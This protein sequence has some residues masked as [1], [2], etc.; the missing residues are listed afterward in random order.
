MST[1]T[2]TAPPLWDHQE[3][4]IEFAMQRRGSLLAHGMGGGK[5]RTAV[6]IAERTNARCV[7]VLCPKSVVGVWPS[8]FR[9]WSPRDWE[10]WAGR[11][12]GLHGKPLKDPSVAKRAVAAIKAHT[13]SVKLDKP[14]VAV[15]NYESAYLG[16]LAQ[17]TMA[18]EWDLVILDES[19]RCKGASGKQARHA[20]RTCHRTRGRG[21]KALLL[22]GTPMPHSPLDIW[23]QMLAVDSGATLGT[24]YTQFTHHFGQPE[25]YYGPGGVK[26]ERFAGLRDD[27]KDEFAGLLSRH[28]H[29]VP[30]DELDEALGLI[31]PVDTTRICT[32]GPEARQAYDAMQK[33]LLAFISQREV[34]AANA[35]V[36]TTKLAQLSGG[37]CKTPDGDIVY[38]SDPPEKAQLLAD[39]LDEIPADEPIVVFARFHADLDQIARVAA[40]TGRQYGEISGRRR[41]GLSADSKLQPGVLLLGVQLQAGGVGIDLTRAA[42]CVFYSLDFRL[43]D[44]LQSRKRVHRPGQTRR[45]TYVH[46]LAE[47]TL[48]R[49]VIGSLAKREDAVA[50]ALVHIRQAQR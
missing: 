25:E 16:N 42:V 21:G 44:Y 38:A 14:F 6:E 37:F 19:H 50:A 41:D 22:T 18:V 35:M 15:I 32:L 24:S 13:D 2:I 28:I 26:K 11:T 12:M 43:A 30:Q 7:L 49:A 8:Q 46:L 4:A 1:T 31:E 10:I 17:W 5:S 23:A 9:T 40:A 36:L 33:D 34:E 45:V 48:D 20:A 29:Q 39:L 47:D 27:R 3:D